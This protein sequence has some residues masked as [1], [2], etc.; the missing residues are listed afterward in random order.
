M[1]EPLNVYL[2][3]LGIPLHQQPPNS[4]RLLG[5]ELYEPD[6]DI[7]AHAADRQMA[8]IRTLSSGEHATVAQQLLNE[9]AAARVKLLNPQKKA[10]Y[11]ALLHFDLVGQRGQSPQVPRASVEGE[12]SSNIDTDEDEPLEPLWRNPAVLATA[13]ICGLLVVGICTALYLRSRPSGADV[14]AETAPADELPPVLSPGEL[15]AVPVAEEP[16]SEAPLAAEKLLSPSENSS[17]GALPQQEASK[18]VPSEKS[19]PVAEAPPAIVMPE[20]KVPAAQTSPRTSSQTETTK[21][22]TAIVETKSVETGVA[23]TDPAEMT[24]EA[25]ALAIT[26]DD[27]GPPEPID[28]GRPYNRPRLRMAA[29]ALVEQNRTLAQVKQIF[30]QEYASVKTPEQKRELGNFLMRQVQS[31]RDDPVSE[32]VLLNECVALGKEGGDLA[33]TLKA[34]EQLEKHFIVDA[35]SMRIDLLNEFARQTKNAAQRQTIANFAIW[36]AGEAAKEHKFDTAEKLVSQAQS[37]AL[38]LGN[39]KQREQARELMAEFKKRKIAWTAIE[40]AIERLD[41]EP[42]NGQAHLIYGKYLCL[43]AK[44]W[45]DGLEHLAQ[46]NDSRLSSLAKQDLAE[47]IEPDAQIALADAW[48]EVAHANAEFTNFGFREHYW[49]LQAL[50]ETTGL[51]RAK[52]ERRLRENTLIRFRD[53]WLSL[54]SRADLEKLN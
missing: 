36:L 42:G 46:S 33:F 4:Y 11:D 34:I 52:V 19:S 16:A 7:I 6:L 20:N 44:D 29:P 9:I 28:D 37:M 43:E 2:K 12:H 24:A 32:F 3:W 1:A 51:L 48:H 54:P 35:L 17:N 30:N 41:T 49:Y 38:R 14:I 53:R 40:A 25:E 31:L 21:P 50:P 13:V 23:Q 18:E 15:A 45:M 10:S 22:S 27:P 47:P 5:I 26:V 8:H 39:D